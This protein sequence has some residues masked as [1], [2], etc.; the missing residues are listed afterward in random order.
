[1]LTTNIDTAT[2]LQAIQDIVITYKDHIPYYFRKEF[3]LTTLEIIMKNTL[4][5]FRDSFLIQLQGTLMCTPAAPQYSILT[6]G[7]YKNQKIY[8]SFNNNLNYYEWYI[9]DVFGIW[10][11]TADD[12]W[13]HFKSTINQFSILVW[14]IEEP[15]ATTTFLGLELT[16]QNKKILPKHIKTHEPISILNPRH[17]PI[18]PAASKA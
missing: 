10:M 7:L 12:T 6:F 9:D 8:N 5:T 16:I 1:M 13:A 14:N 17:Q 11:D 18:H 4:F 3:F 2:G 15:T